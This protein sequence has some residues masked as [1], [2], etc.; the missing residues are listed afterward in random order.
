MN[1]FTNL[2]GRI[3]VIEPRI[4]ENS[5]KKTWG[6]QTRLVEARG[7]FLEGEVN[8]YTHQVLRGS[9]ELGISS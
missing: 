7:R 5:L 2:K 3:K 6:S 9:Y 1:E 4:R 8:N